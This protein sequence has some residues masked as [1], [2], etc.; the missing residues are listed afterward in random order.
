MFEVV[1]L[2]HVRTNRSQS[3]GCF[4]SHDRWAGRFGRRGPLRRHRTASQPASPTDRRRRMMLLA[5]L[6]DRLVKQRCLVLV[7][8]QGRSHRFG[9]PGR[10]ADVVI[11]LHDP[12]LARRIYLHPYPALGAAYLDGGLKVDKGRDRKRGEWGK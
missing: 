5:A 6:L 1:A 9:E 3:V 10:E 7:D 2:R 8:H 12:G 4:A 11:S